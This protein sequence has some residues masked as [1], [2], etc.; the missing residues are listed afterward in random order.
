MIDFILKQAEFNLRMIEPQKEHLRRSLGSAVL[1]SVADLDAE[2]RTYRMVL[3]C[4][5]G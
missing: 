5:E 1:E 3:N 4:I 2:D